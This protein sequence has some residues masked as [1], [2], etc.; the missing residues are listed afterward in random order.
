MPTGSAKRPRARWA[1]VDADPVS[2]DD[3]VR[4]QGGV[5]ALR[6]AVACGM[7]A[8]TVQR[9]ARAGSWRRLNPAVYLLAGHRLTDEVRVRAASA[10]GRRGRGG[11]RPG[12]GLLARHAGPV[13]ADR[14]AHDPARELSPVP[15]RRAGASAG[16]CTDRRRRQSRPVADR[17]AADRTGDRGG[18]SRRIGLPRPRA[19][20]PRPVPTGVPRLLPQHR[21]ARLVRRGGVARS[22]SEPGRLRRR[23][24]AGT[25]A[26]RRRHRRVGARASLRALAHRPGVSAAEGRGRGGRVGLARR[27]RT[28]PCRPP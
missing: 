18:A 17:R 22:R 1:P 13:A 9:R 8:A 5:L 14:R 12:G 10:V 15:D 19:A 16:S 21:Q 27:C 7:S 3:L 20:A 11:V 4:R 23:A 6:Q 28:L 26:A 24:T 2:L 25:P